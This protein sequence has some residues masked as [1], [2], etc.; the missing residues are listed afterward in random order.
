MENPNRTQ[1]QAGRG[2][3]IGHFATEVTSLISGGEMICY[4]LFLQIHNTVY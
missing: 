3:V 4:S 1:R 2:R